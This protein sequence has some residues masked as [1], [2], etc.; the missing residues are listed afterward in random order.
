M[1]DTPFLVEIENAITSGTSAKRLRALKRVSD[2]FATGSSR[3]SNDEIAVFD[4]VLLKLA[5]LV[6]TDARAR[7]ARRLAPLPDAPPRMVR[8]LARDRAIEVA[9][10]VLRQS[11]RLAEP[12]LVESASTQGQDHLFAI[13]QR[14][15][16]SENVTD[17]LVE[18]GNR[19]VAHTV[20]KN[21]GARFSDFG[22]DK[23]VDRAGKDDILA[24]SLGL[25]RDI[26]RQHFLKLLHTASARV[27]TKLA[28]G[29]RAAAVAVNQAV[30]EATA[31][32]SSEVRDASRE[33]AKAK[34]SSKRRYNSS[35]LSELNL[36]AAAA[37][38]NFEKTVAALALLG[39][40][41]VDLVERGLLDENPDI[42]LILARAAGCSRFTTKALLLMRA[43]G[44]GMSPSDVEAALASYDRI[45]R[46]TANRLINY[47]VTRYYA[48]DGAAQFRAA[49][50]PPAP[51]S[52]E[53]LAR[54]IRYIPRR[55][56]RRRKCDERIQTP[57]R[58]SQ[59]GRSFARRTAF[60]RGHGRRQSRLPLRSARHVSGTA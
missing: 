9:G 4:D 20:A 37:A 19:R 50:P 16:L 28:A 29:N 43:A 14:R 45:G 52:P 33:F 51:S 30:A 1:P 39:H 46:A 11:E 22:F 27:R 31:S 3:Y 10:P 41:P 55:N 48:E 38:Q 7:L 58:T 40:L 42:L 60:F 13:S 26:P 23:L 12:D 35:Q 25:R 15:T 47:Y 24:E 49:A 5:K 32:I 54:R 56:F 53:A 8:A 18:R 21:A 36:H 34:K 59:A 6:E 57:T 44:R 2:L 17:I